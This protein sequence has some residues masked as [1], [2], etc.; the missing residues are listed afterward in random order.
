VNDPVSF[1][2]RKQ[3]PVDPKPL[4][5]RLIKEVDEP[6]PSSLLPISA[7]IIVNERDQT[8]IGN[9]E[10]SAD[11]G[12]L[13]RCWSA[14]K[15]FTELVFGA[16][17][18][19]VGL[20]ALAV[21]PILQFLSLGYF[22]EA[23][24]RVARSGRLRDGFIGLRKAARMGCAVIALWLIIAPLRFLSSLYV[25]AQ[26]I[27]PQSRMVTV[28]GVFLAIFTVLAAA[29]MALALAHGGRLR[30]FLWP[31]GNILH[32]YGR[33][34]NGGVYSKLRDEFWDFFV[35]L[36]LP[37]YFWLGLRGF[38]GSLIWL[39]IPI[40]MLAASSKAPIIGVFGALLL[41]WVVMVLPFLQANFAVE[42]KFRAHFALR[43]VRE[44]FRHAPF[45]FAIAL[46]AAL[47]FP[48][49]L[50]LLK[51]ELVAGEAGW[52]PSLFF[53]TFMFP[54]RLVTGWAYGR[55]MRREQRSHF[56]WRFV[57]K[58]GL[59]PIAAFYT[60]M[61]FLSQYTSWE[62]IGSLYGQHAFLLPVP[63]FEFGNY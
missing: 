12:L 40:S 63:F 32:F 35:S 24:R 60:L 25:S 22:F 42:N 26:V 57:T 58:P 50:Y 39:L 49:P 5:A 11:K 4:S 31:V 55:S 6:E 41:I 62:G 9:P 46:T 19:I 15:S 21:I 14:F 29:H 56:F 44:K 53:I 27:D 28:I 52:L 38:I 51:V 18:L 33:W 48:L 36:R 59:L 37:Y 20:A 3:E 1:L 47:L 23:T 7:R 30:D 45:A 2:E 54:A 61:V 10:E 17:S 8:H 34:K 13:S 43:T 16:L